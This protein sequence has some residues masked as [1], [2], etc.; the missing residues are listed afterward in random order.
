MQQ[1]EEYN[2]IKRMWVNFFDKI[3]LFCYNRSNHILSLYSGAQ[4]IQIEFGADAKR[5]RIIPNGVDVDTLIDTIKNRAKTPKPIVTLIG[6]VVPIK[7]IKTFIR[8]I[9]I[10]SETIPDIEGWIVGSVSEDREYV[11]E[12]QH[13]AISLGLKEEMQTFNGDK[14]TLSSNI[15]RESNEKIKFFGHSDIKEILPLS[16]LQ[17][18]SSISEGMPLVIL[19]G[20]AAGVPCVATD[21][22][23]CRDLIEGGINTEDI[24]IGKAGA[25]VGIANPGALAQEYTRFLTF[26]NGE[27][28]KAQE[29]SI[30][31]VQRYYREE[32]F[33]QD[34]KALYEEAIG[35]SWT[36]LQTKLTSEVK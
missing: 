13:M 18:L 6:R 19:E 15:L 10:A 4:K 17:T 3:G 33:L 24:A 16:A 29:V 21:V 30:N 14:T 9:K 11:Q 25:I 1:P 8:A 34:Y 7:D 32:L 27:W 23:S 12:C 22:G 35:S 20:F 26:E 31:R 28:K 2:Y 36:L 5:T